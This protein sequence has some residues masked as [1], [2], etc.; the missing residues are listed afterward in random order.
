[1]ILRKFPHLYLSVVIL[2]F[3]SI[4]PVFSQENGISVTFKNNSNN[5]LQCGIFEQDDY[6]PFIN[7]DG[8]Q[9]RHFD[10]FTVG[11]K[12][13]CSIA[14]DGRSST[15]L[16][17]FDVTSAGVHEL[18]IDKVPCPSCREKGGQDWRWATIIVSPDGHAN[19]NRLK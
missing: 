5:I 8:K 18:L 3:C 1:M 12:V 17:Y 15:V 14:I 7:L 13:R 2:F 19:Y 6:V 16:T 4:F 11:S 9:D 10:N